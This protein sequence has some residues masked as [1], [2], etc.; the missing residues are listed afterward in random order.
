MVKIT[1]PG[2][3]QPTE[4]PGETADVDRTKGTGFT[5]KLDKTESVSAP[6]TAAKTEE[7]KKTLV[8]DIGQDLKDGKITVEGA[9]NEVVDRVL[10][11]QLGEGAPEPVKKQVR[12]AVENALQDPVV[13]D[14]I[15][16]LS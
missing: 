1:G 5:D 14:K 15:K 4:G 11:N 3:G 13:A 6:Q 12:E 7:P 10:K 2:S 16:S 8:S 9:L